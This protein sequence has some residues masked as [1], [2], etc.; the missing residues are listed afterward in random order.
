MKLHLTTFLALGLA[1]MVSGVCLGTSTTQPTNDDEKIILN[2]KVNETINQ[3]KISDPDI[4]NFFDKAYGYAV[5]PSIGNGA[6]V[7]GAAYGK[8]EVFENG[9][10][11]ANLV[12]DCSV[13]QG[14]IGAQ[15]GAQVF[16]EVIFF[17]D[18]AAFAQFT[19]GQLAF[20]ARASAVAVTAGA[21][22]AVDYQHGVV[23]FT[24]SQTGLM[25]QAAIGGQ[26]FSYDPI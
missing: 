3:F 17:Q 26:K 16:S 13:T 22:T 20:D 1:T 14:S 8:G 15:I 12:G 9:L 23:V 11:G 4:S 18:K 5:F 6:V 10:L 19:S 7:V 25:V 2:D 21:S 24:M